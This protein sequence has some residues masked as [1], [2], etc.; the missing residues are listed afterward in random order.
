MTL[1]L[2]NIAKERLSE[3]ITRELCINR[4]D[5]KDDKFY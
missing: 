5:C 1:L 3:Y 2:S 4:D